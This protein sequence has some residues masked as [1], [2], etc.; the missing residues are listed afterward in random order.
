[1]IEIL[2]A[3]VAMLVLALAIFTIRAQDLFAAAFGFIAYGL[4]LT[5]VW[6]QLGGI[7]VALTEAAIGGGL[8]GALVIGS[9]ARL[10][11]TQAHSGDE[12]PGAATRGFAALAAVV[13]AA[14]LATCVVA[15]PDPPPSL[16]P[17][18]A[19]NMASMGV[20]NPITAVLLG[21]RAMD[22]L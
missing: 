6:V 7:D 3:G 11:A 4:L 18:V 17:Q 20:G 1:M 9:A 13:V 19:A 15:L 10:W 22:T 16:A 5:L 8:T 14:A 2:N 21:F 12:R